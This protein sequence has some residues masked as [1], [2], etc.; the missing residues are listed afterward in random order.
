M[1]EKGDPYENAMVERVN[2]ILK[3]EFDLDRVFEDHQQALIAVNG[4]IRI[5]NNHKPYATGRP[6]V[7]I[8]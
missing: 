1:T 8:F 3:D 4:G 6:A 7:V 5:Y 2:G